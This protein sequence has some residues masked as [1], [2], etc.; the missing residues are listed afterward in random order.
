M[1]AAA[2]LAAAHEL[3]ISPRPI[4]LADSFAAFAAFL[5]LLL[6]P[7]S[8]YFYVFHG[9]WFMLYLVDVRRVPS[10]LALFG[11]LAELAIG[12][13]GFVFS[14]VCV[15]NQRNPWVVTALV[16]CLIG[17]LGVVALYPE[18][19]RVLGTFRQYQGG[20]GLL[21]Y[22]GSLLQG[23]LAMG[24]LLVV[25]GTFLLVRIRRGQARI[26]RS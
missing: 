18:R 17:S 20:F 26:Q 22:G 25:G 11:F 23:A 14:A 16:G 21:P 6:L 2:A 12:F 13:L 5:L 10:A 24:G 19:L 3:R 4:V 15:R 1:G 9:D 7:V 8:V